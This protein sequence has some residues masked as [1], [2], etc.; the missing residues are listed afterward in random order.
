MFNYT[1]IRPGLTAALL[2]T[3]ALS[4]GHS[5]QVAVET[6]GPSIRKVRS[7]TLRVQNDPEQ[8][9]DERLPIE[10]YPLSPDQLSSTSTYYTIRVDRRRC[11]T[12]LCGGY[13]VKRVNQSRTRCANGRF[14]AQCYVAEIDWN[15]QPEIEP[16]NALLRGNIVAKR[17]PSFGNLG[18]F[19]VT[20]SWQAV[21][22]NPAPGTFFRV[23]DRGIRCITHPCLTH[24][25]A[26]L[27]STFSRNVAGVELEAAGASE[28]S[29]AKA[30]EEMGQATGMI[31]NGATVTVTGPAGRALAVR[32]AQF[33]LRPG[34]EAPNRPP[35][36]GRPSK[37]DCRK[38]GCSGQVCSDEDVTTTCEWRPEYACYRNARCERQSN[39]KCGFTQTPELAA[40]LARPPRP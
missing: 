12:P 9:F 28:N 16:G 37:N 32:A 38:T 1:S 14:A 4:M 31:I 25:A 3:L 8:N 40:C 36:T 6:S 22:N 20:E 24:H 15:G 30:H 17:F 19:R 10:S 23:R 21:S 34:D 26:R 27:N 29:I 39:G 35:E 18:S 7:D 13:F 5:P 33:Y 11:V 2:A